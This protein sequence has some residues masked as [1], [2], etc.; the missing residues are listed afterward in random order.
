MTAV[1]ALDRAH[2]RFPGWVGTFP[3]QL[4]TRH[5][6]THGSPSCASAASVVSQGK[7]EENDTW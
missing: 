4:R 6:I 5:E 1:N 2:H 3:V 7:G